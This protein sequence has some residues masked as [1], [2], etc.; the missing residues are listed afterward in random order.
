MSTPDKLI[1]VSAEAA[2]KIAAILSQRP[3]KPYFRLQIVGGGCSGFEYVFGIDDTIREQD[4]YQAVTAS[5][6]AF[7]VLIDAISYQYVQQAH[8]DYIEDTS[9]ARFVVTNPNAATSCSCGSSFA[10]KDQGAAS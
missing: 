8:V 6:Q 9:G 1:S 10:L 3:E 4:F 2:S 7:K 5:P